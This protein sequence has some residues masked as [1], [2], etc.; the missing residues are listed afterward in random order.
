M[1]RYVDSKVAAQ[2][3]GKSEQH[4]CSMCRDGQLPGAVKNGSRWKIPAD[5]HPKLAETEGPEN[6]IN[7]DELSGIPVYKRDEALRRLGTIQD[8]ERFVG[9]LFREDRERQ[10]RQKEFEP[11]VRTEAIG[12]YAAGHDITK[13]TLERWL[14]RYRSQGL[15]GLVD[16]RGGGKFLNELISLEAFE[17]F[18][19]MY[20]TQQQLSV[21]LCWQNINF[22][23]K[24]E[25]KGWKI[26]QLPFMYRY[27]KS[28]IPLGVQ[29]LYREG[30]AAYEA[31]CAPYIE[32]DPDSVEPGE[33]WVGDH[34]QF[35]CWVRHRGKW[36]RPWITAWEDMRS[37]LIV[38]WHITASP[39]QTTILLAMKRG[40]EQYGPPDSAKIDNGRDYDSEC[41]TGQTK[42]KRRALKK[43]YIDKEI[44]VGIY[45]MMGVGVSFAIPYN[46]KAKRIERLFA[47]IDSQLIATMPTYC[48]K[49]TLRKPED[50]NKKL[51]EPKVIEGALDLE[52][53]AELFG[54]YA[55]VYN[56]SAHT[57]KGMEGRTPAEVFATRSS[58]RV[59]AEGVSE[60]LLR[61]WSGELTIGKN[62]VRFN[63]MWYGQNDMDL[64][65][66][67]GKKVRVSYDPDDLRRV[68]VYDS[69][70]LKLITIAEQN[71]LIRYGSQVGEEDLRE[72]MHRKTRALRNIRD[73]R[74]SQLTANMDLTA[75]TIKAMRDGQKKPAE[76]PKAAKMLRPVKTPLDG[77]VR[78][79]ERQEILKEVK[80]AAG[81]ESVE[82]VLDFDFSLFRPENEYE[83][84]RL[85][86]DE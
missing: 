15:L 41:W 33:V 61:V 72:A 55:E 9:V 2:R 56:N 26:P 46:A 12:L 20:L 42:T 29:I 74:D 77:Q 50:L 80:K 39:N 19:S 58:R 48:G 78:E 32:I 21:K 65:A 31:K 52:R 60:L 24:N 59:M 63:K 4:I 27:I 85:L 57:G 13:R 5:A 28:Q 23:N 67:Q 18:K 70:T 75:L 1:T 81:A 82:K 3:L 30:I 25:G 73:Y 22:V 51:N 86:D 43:G 8:F 71:E 84:V 17:L 10:L 64:I 45:A 34:S 40:L 11:R 38:G 79:H 44:V 7:S 16:A 47:T 66:H 53:F 36:I 83:G 62:G 49:D 69:V 6:L 68:Y 14:A 54:Q 35:N 76:K 37:R